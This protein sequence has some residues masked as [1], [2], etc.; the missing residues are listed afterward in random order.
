[1]DEAKTVEDLDSRYVEYPFVYSGMTIEAYN[2]EKE[3]YGKHW[4][5]VRKGTYSPLWKQRG[6]KHE[7]F[8]PFR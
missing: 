1:M 6:E 5:E 4:A 3:Y 2:E 8:D 7:K